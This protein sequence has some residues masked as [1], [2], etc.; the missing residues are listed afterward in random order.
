MHSDVTDAGMKIDQPASLA[1]TTLTQGR[2]LVRFAE[3]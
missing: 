2:P 1:V 3:S